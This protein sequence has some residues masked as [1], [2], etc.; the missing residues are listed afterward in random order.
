MSSPVWTGTLELAGIP[1]GLESPVPL[2]L[3]PHLRP[4]LAPER[5]P[6]LRIRIDCHWP[7]PAGEAC[8]EEFRGG[9]YE[10]PWGLAMEHRIWAKGGKNPENPWLIP[11]SRDE[12]VLRIPESR[13]DYLAKGTDFS[14]LLGLE[15]LFAARNRIIL[16]STSVV[17]GGKAWLFSAPSG[18]GKSTHA[19]LWTDSFGSRPLTGD[20]TVL[21]KRADGGITAYGSPL[22]GSSNLTVRD[23]APLGGVLVLVQ[24]PEN[25]VEPLS[26]AQAFR[27]LL[28]QTSVF[29][30]D[31][32]HVDRCCEVITQ[33]VRRFPVARLVCRPDREAA[34][35]AR[36][37]AM[38]L[39]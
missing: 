35:L 31:S 19:A 13:L 15:R 22:C 5:S 30:W 39:G 24:G 23:N 38:K 27:A 11:V 37:W 9:F 4:F 32:R 2:E 28:S 26:Q 14:Y 10:T 36:S 20:R 8:R 33:L 6:E 21:E 12:M 25:R 16:H 18:T 3:H 34:E 1:I 29:L 7:L 17:E